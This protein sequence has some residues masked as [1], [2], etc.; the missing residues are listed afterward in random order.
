MLRPRRTINAETTRAKLD[1]LQAATQREVEL[2]EADPFDDARVAAV[3]GLIDAM[4]GQTS[5]LAGMEA[6]LVKATRNAAR[7]VTAAP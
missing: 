6:G 5:A 2:A 1:E 3:N 4:K 7:K